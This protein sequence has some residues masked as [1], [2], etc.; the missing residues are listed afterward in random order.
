M[1]HRYLPAIFISCFAILFALTNQS[2]AGTNDCDSV[3]EELSS[4]FRFLGDWRQDGKPNYLENLADQ[5]S[6]GLIDFVINT[7]PEH[8]NL[9]NSSDEY[10]GNNVQLNTELTERSKVFLTMVHEGANWKNTLG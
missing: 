1:K 4:Q 5:V 7:L 3:N 9:P 10:F 2:N 8:M 6:P